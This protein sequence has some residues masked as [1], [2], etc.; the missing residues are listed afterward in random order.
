MIDNLTILACIFT[1]FISLVLPIGFIIY[2]GVKHKGQGIASAWILGALGFVVTQMCIRVPILAAIAKIEGATAF[3]INHYIFFVL[4]L[5]VTAALFEF[6]GRFATAKIMARKNLTYR[7]SLAAGLGHGGIEAI[8]LVGITYI[9]SLVYIFMIQTGS[10]ETLIAQAAA[11]GQNVSQLYTIRDTI[12]TTPAWLFFLGGIERLLTMPAHAA[13]SMLVCW[14]VHTK[15]PL[16]PF[17]WCLGIHTF[18]DGV[19]G[20]VMAIST[21][22]LAM[23]SQ[24]TA[25]FITYP[26]LAA[27]AVL[28]LFIIRNIHKM[29]N[30][31]QEVSY[32]Q[33]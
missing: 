26:I 2:Y 32:V 7:R 19:C 16:K 1:L 14:G 31:E 11:A 3:S 21:P 30:P 8:I 5:A 4:S 24:T 6:A 18:I 25:Y 33:E 10:F 27:V 13:M 28:S 20:M 17:L 9:N 22:E 29:W 15:K 23:I 12:L